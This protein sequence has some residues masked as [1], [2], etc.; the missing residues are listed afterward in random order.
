MYLLSTITTVWV[1]LSML[2]CAFAS[3]PPDGVPSFLVTTGPGQHAEGFGKAFGD[4][5]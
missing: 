2:G 4:G 1:V 5:P 3:R